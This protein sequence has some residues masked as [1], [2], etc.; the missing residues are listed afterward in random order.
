MYIHTFTL[1]IPQELWDKLEQVCARRKIA[2][3]VR[4]AIQEKLDKEIDMDSPL[5]KETT[6]TQ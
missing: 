2:E 4:D 1:Q 3:F 6:K 5:G